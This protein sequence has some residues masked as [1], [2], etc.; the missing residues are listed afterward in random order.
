MKNNKWDNAWFTVYP[1]HELHAS[2]RKC[3]VEGEKGEKYKRELN[4][5]MTGKLVN[6]S[7]GREDKK[8]NFSIA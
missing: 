8:G 7:R 2:M 1:L 5:L 4:L 3:M 6:L